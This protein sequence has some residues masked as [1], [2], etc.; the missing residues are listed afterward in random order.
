[1]REWDSRYIVR[2]LASRH[3]EPSLFGVFRAGTIAAPLSIY[4]TRK[5]AE[6]KALEL[7]TTRSDGTTR[8]V[9]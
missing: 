4:T 1:M 3:G 2:E 9:G 6:R 5:R 8:L 7:T